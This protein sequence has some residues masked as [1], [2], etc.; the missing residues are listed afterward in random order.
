[1]LYE[2]RAFVT[3]FQRESPVRKVL[4]LYGCEFNSVEKNESTENILVKQPWMR[5]LLPTKDEAHTIAKIMDE[6]YDSYYELEG[7]FGDLEDN[8]IHPYGWD[9]LQFCLAA[10]EGEKEGVI[11]EDFCL[12]MLLLL[13]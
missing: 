5:K 2:I 7:V 6:L 11:G 12:Q 3:A 9:N 4:D 13:L 10:K 1:M 8:R